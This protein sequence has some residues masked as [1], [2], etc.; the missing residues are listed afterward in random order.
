[1][2][3]IVHFR[4]ARAIRRPGGRIL[5]RDGIELW[6]RRYGVDWQAFTGPGVPEA[7]FEAIDDHYAGVVLKIAREEAAHGQQ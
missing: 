2:T 3:V 6:C 7:V 1:M 5:C 4:H